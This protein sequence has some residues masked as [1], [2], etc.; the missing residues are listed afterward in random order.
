[1]HARLRHS[2]LMLAPPWLTARSD[3]LLVCWRCWP[4]GQPC[5]A[6]I[7]RSAHAHMHTHVLAYA[8]AAAANSCPDDLASPLFHKKKSSSHAPCIYHVSS[9]IFEPANLAP[10]PGIF[11]PGGAGRAAC[12][13]SVPASPNIRPEKPAALPPQT[14]STRDGGWHT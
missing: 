4:R 6:S 8:H 7:E 10:F 3:V 1:M 9:Q 2:L 14:P 12:F 5:G 11:L 13:F